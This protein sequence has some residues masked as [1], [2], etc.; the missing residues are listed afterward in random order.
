MSI[1]AILVI[2]IGIIV[3]VSGQVAYLF[4]I[5]HEMMK[6]SKG[7]VKELQQQMKQFQPG[8]EEFK[9]VYSELMAENSRMMKQSFKP[10]YVTFVPFIII[11]LVMSSYLSAIPTG[12]GSNVQMVLSG[13][14]NGTISFSSNCI[15]LD[16]S[17]NITVSSSNL[18]QSFTA[19]I[20]SATCTAF[21]A[22]GSTIYNTSIT[23]LV[24]SHSKK[25]Y[26]LGDTTLKFSPNPVI[27]TTLPF[28]IPFIGSKITWFWGYVFF[29]FIASIILNRVFKH[30]KM[31]S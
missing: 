24:G 14:V 29:S 22:Q 10:T 15:T 4:L 28:S 9:K 6:S 20:N 2:L 11:F 8:S 19:Q 27:I 7:K 31:I 17:S 13:A 30:Y 21:L 18:P 25:S 26:T 12:V 5:D 3:G 1:D 23:G 16:N